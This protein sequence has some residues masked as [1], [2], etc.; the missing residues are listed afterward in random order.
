MFQKILVVCLG[1]ICRSPIGEKLLQ[2]HLPDKHIASAGLGTQ[3]SGLL[4]KEADHSANQI[5]QEH[6]LSLEGHKAQQLTQSLCQ[7]YDLIL[8]MEKK[9]LES[10]CHLAPEVRGKTMLFGQWLSQKEIPDPYMKSR[11]AF[12][13][14]YRQLELASQAWANKIK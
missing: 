8:V 1:N 3:K 9:H 7:N 11:E 4:G 2:Q 14:A 12:E 13:F 6:G 10:I 5:A